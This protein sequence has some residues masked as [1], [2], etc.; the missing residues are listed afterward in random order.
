MEVARTS[1]GGVSTQV[2]P[3]LPKPPGSEEWDVA[4]EEWDVVMSEKSFSDYQTALAGVL[5]LG[6]CC[7]G[8]GIVV[9]VYSGRIDGLRLIEAVGTVVVVGLV[10][11]G[12]I[13]WRRVRISRAGTQQHTATMRH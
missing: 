12:L 11:Y 6:L 13:R 8:P 3:F 1:V 2:P 10:V 7:A 4:M 9:A 5:L